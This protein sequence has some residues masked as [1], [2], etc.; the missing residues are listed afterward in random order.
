VEVPPRVV[1]VRFNESGSVDESFGRDG[2]IEGPDAPD[3][4]SVWA[5]LPDGHISPRSPNVTRVPTEPPGASPFHSRP[6]SRQRARGDGSVRLGL[7]AL[8]GVNE[9]LPARDGSLVMLGTVDPAHPA[10]SAVAVRRIMPGG[11]LD[12]RFGT[13]CGRSG[14]RAGT[15]GGAATPD[16]GIIATARGFVRHARI[17][18]FVFRYG[19]DGCVAGRPV[20]IRAGSAGPPVLHGRRTALVAATYGRTPAGFARGLALIRIRH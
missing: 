7:N 8:D 2:V 17:D 9:L 3:Y 20:R 18:S 1:F 19:T 16:G 4:F 11:R 10:G 13:A 14:P 12:A 6:C 15:T 5:A